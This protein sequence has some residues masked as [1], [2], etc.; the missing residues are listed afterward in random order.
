[1]NFES[2]I[3]DNMIIVELRIY[4]Y[5]GQENQNTVDD[6]TRADAVSVLSSDDWLVNNTL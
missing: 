5:A 1:M 4:R 2:E 3:N 6:S